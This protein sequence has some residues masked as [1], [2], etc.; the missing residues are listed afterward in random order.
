MAYITQTLRLKSRVSVSANGYPPNMVANVLGYTVNGVAISIPC[1]DG[2]FHLI[3]KNTEVNIA[4]FS[5]SGQY[6]FTS[7]VKKRVLLN[8]TPVLLIDKP[9]KLV[10]SERREYYR[11]DTL[12]SVKLILATTVG[13]GRDRQVLATEY[14]AMCVDISAGGIRLD[15]VSSHTLPLKKGMTLIVDFKNA[16]EGI[17]RLKAETVRPPRTNTDGWGLK[18][19][20]L[21]DANEAK[22]ARYVNKK[23]QKYQ[24]IGGG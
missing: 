1:K 19:V 12:F 17:N 18:F 6:S 5:G 15:N 24:N 7:K 3:P 13:E 2:Y 9:T 8:D 14:S 21:S 20:N 16:I 22:I 10:R 4:F 11:I 23:S